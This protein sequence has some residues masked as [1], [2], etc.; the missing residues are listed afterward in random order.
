MEL[1]GYIGSISLAICGLPQCIMSIKQGHSNGISLGF[2]LLWTIG[3]ILTLVY[4]LPKLDIPLLLNYSANIIFLTV[5]W[6]Y[7]LF[8]RIK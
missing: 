6:K 7:R 5:I 4:I 8:P 2:L 3:E 1:I